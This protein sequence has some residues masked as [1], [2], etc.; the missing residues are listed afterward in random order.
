MF[1][2]ITFSLSTHPTTSV[3]T[4]LNHCSLVNKNKT[5][6]SPQHWPPTLAWSY[7][8]SGVPM[9]TVNKLLWSITLWMLQTIKKQY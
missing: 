6:I 4:Y 5:H 2:M 8:R 1:T 3:V 9:K 7:E